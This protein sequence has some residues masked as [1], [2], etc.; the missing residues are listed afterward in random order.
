[1]LKFSADGS[2]PAI[3]VSAERTDDGWRFS[4]AD[5]GIGIEPEHRERVFEMFRRLHGRDKP[6][7]GIG[8]TICQKVVARH[9]GRIWVEP[10]DD[11]G[12]V[13]STIPDRQG[14]AIASSGGRD[15]GTAV[16]VL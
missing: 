4:V 13:R 12:D 16:P 10:S 2:S 15:D 7:T 5:N 1:A 14:P 8:L 6:G 9:G 3:H 11:G